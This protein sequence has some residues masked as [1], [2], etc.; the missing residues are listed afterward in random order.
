MAGFYYL[1]PSGEQI[2]AVDLP[3]Q[4]HYPR[5]TTAWN[6][7]RMPSLV[8]GR[9]LSRWS[10]GENSGRSEAADGR[11][12]SDFR[13]MTCIAGSS[14]GEREESEKEASLGFL[15]RVFALTEAD[16]NLRKLDKNAP[17]LLLL[18]T[19][20]GLVVREVPV[21]RGAVLS[22]YC[23]LLL[24]CTQDMFIEFGSSHFWVRAPLVTCGD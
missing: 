20:E 11:R 1:P 16:R 21:A 3:P 4:A 5:A 17:F 19:G 13:R 23:S 7:K 14:R 8:R 9:N 12:T 18:I 2:V 15:F 24:S 6:R 10:S 22:A